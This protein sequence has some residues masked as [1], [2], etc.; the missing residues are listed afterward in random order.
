MRILL[1]FVLLLILP[2]TSWAG[3][4]ALVI[5]NSDYQTVPALPNPINDAQAV[6]EALRRQGFEVTVAGNM[7]RAQMLTTLRGFRDRAD[8]ADVAM[9]YYAGHGM[10]I[11]GRNYLIPVD[12]RIADER[13]ARLEMI[14]MQ[15]VL[16]QLSGAKRMKMI[17]LDAC[18]DN[19]FITRM[20]RE[21]KGR[22]VGRGLA[23]VNNAGADTL[24]A[25][26]AAAGEVTPDG[27]EGENSP[28]TKAFLN[29][30]SGPPADIRLLLGQV[31]DE[32]RK[33][34]PGSA[35]FVYSSLGGSQYILNRNS[36]APAQSKPTAP[37]SAALDEN[38]LLI[39][40][41]TAEISDTATAWEEFLTKY[42]PHSGHTLYVLA[43]RNRDRLAAVAAAAASEPRSS[44][45]PLTARPQPALQ[46]QQL[47][48]L[49][50]PAATAPS[51]RVPPTP[52]P[53][54][55]RKQALLEIQRLLKGRNCY[56]GRLDGIYGRQT[57]AGLRTLSAR[58]KVPLKV[59]KNSSVADMADVI[60]RLVVIDDIKCPA[61]A[62][63]RKPAAK[64][65]PPAKKR[66]P[67]VAA[68][69]ARAPVAKTAP[70]TKKSQSG[71]TIFK[72]P[73]NY[74]PQFGSSPGCRDGSP[75][76]Y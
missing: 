61:V 62:V 49:D 31:R 44:S 38:A 64:P 20:Q 35:P 1:I 42:Q 57:A 52:E 73:P 51:L 26:A 40:F 53:E 29:A 67:T 10:E 6:A 24:I 2:A 3:N 5:G 34:V 63:V 76:S 65:R 12:A 48:A 32:L 66:Q 54:M 22:N 13:D 74:C 33:S 72:N 4:V 69:T 36:Q 55:T 19:P 46:P 75:I 9:V 27:L 8:Q 28:F 70:K 30:L 7:N 15:D 14:E 58:A 11:A 17:V 25:Y 59:D 16:A 37:A 47:A 21:K 43:R 56:P 23:I 18:R 68:P 41:A 60:D 50:Q 45:A 39:D 71:Q